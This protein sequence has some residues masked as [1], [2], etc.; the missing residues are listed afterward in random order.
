MAIDFRRFAVAITGFC[1]FLN[2]YAPQALLPELSREFGVGPA[3]ISTMI[4]AGTLAIALTAP[5]TGAIADVLGRKRLITAAMFAAAVPTV[6]VALSSDIHAI[7]VWRFIQGLMLP[8]IF[9][10]ALAY[11]GDEWPP[12]QVAGV[13]GI[14]VAGSS[15]GGFC[16]RLIPG[17]LSGMIDWRASFLVLAAISLFG[18]IVV[19]MT[20]PHERRFRRSEGFV[21]SGRQMLRHICNP[22]LIAIYA[23]GFGVLFNFIAVFTYVSFHLAAPPYDFTPAKLGLLFVTY[24]AGACCAPLTGWAATR[25]GRRRLVLGVMIMWAAGLALLLAAP[26]SVIVLGLV[27]CAACGMVCQAVSTGYVTATAHEGRSSAVGLY[28]SSFYIGGSVGGFVPGLAWS[29]AGWPGVVAL[30]AAVLAIIATIVATVWP[31]REIAA[32]A[33]KT[34]QDR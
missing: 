30:A 33:Q 1:T 2:L 13:A 18:A 6:M 34:T 24:L 31:R 10:V 29:F 16:G 4:T 21:A 26:V 5:F 32:K 9:T 23:V 28:V 8:P 14:Y 3:E 22:Q 7:V 12:A 17:V 11:V 19:V 27:L 15:I 20:L 25:F